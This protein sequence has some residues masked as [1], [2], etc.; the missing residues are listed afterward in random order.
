MLARR[1]VV[2]RSIE[3]DLTRPL[4]HCL[5]QTL[6]SLDVP[7]FEGALRIRYPIYTQAERPPIVEHQIDL[8]H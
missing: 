6:D 2:T 4:R 8:W 5:L 7:S 3:G 1:E